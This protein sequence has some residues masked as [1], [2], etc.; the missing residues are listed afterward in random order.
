MSKK[1]IIIYIPNLSGGGTER[2]Y[3]QLAKFLANMEKFSLTYFYSINLNNT[4]Y[5]NNRYIQYRKTV[6][7]KSIFAILEI[8]LFSWRYKNSLILT[9]QNHAVPQLFGTKRM[10]TAFWYKK[11]VYTIFVQTKMYEIYV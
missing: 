1:K 6:S 10:Y 7:R 9:A 11:D 8:I 5:S 3:T 2:F 4:Q